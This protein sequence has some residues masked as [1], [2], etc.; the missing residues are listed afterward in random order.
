MNRFLSIAV[1]LVIILSLVIFH[2]ASQAKDTLSAQSAERF[3]KN[4]SDTAIAIIK[5]GSQSD[6]AQLEQLESLFKDSVDS[7]WIGKFV[8][9]QYWR[10]LSDKQK[11]EYIAIFEKYLIQLYVPKFKQYNDQS[12]K[13][14][15]TLSES[16]NEYSVM[17]TIILDNQTPINVQY[18]LHLNKSGKIQIFDVIAEG[19]SLLNTQRSE[20]GSV[21][22]RKDADFLISALT[23]KVNAYYTNKSTLRLYK[24]PRKLSLPPTSY[25]YNCKCHPIIGKACDI[26]RFIVI[27]LIKY[28][29]KMLFS[30]LWRRSEYR[31]IEYR[32]I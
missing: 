14:L 15:K 2:V 1:K 25:Q 11:D 30:V 26:G 8:M 7:A 19:V 27:E 32:F 13:I 4:T 22:A 3:I 9:G 17:T 31:A 21:L 18:K 24:I 10:Q 16:G 6:I 5:D 12:Y 23:R 20:F 28:G 29:F